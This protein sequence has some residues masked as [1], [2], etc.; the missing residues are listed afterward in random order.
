LTG[1]Q[2]NIAVG[3]G[4]VLA[5]T[6]SFYAHPS[7]P[8]APSGAFTMRGTYS[9]A[10]VVLL[11]DTW[12]QQP[13][14]YQMVDLRSDPLTDDGTTLTGTIT[15]SGCTTFSLQ[16]ES[17]SAA[18]PDWLTNLTG[19]NLFSCIVSLTA[20]AAGILTAQGAHMPVMIQAI[21]ALSLTGDY[22]AFFRTLTSDSYWDG[23]LKAIVNSFYETLRSCFEGMQG[24]MRLTAGRAGQMVGEWASSV[25]GSRP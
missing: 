10:V 13:T 18:P 15:T 6:F 1:L 8:G 2:L 5:A 14:G 11:Q 16:K 24:A 3:E 21:E 23:L 25:V 12:I 19:Q 4:N 17:D 22:E 20:L 7:N 9:S